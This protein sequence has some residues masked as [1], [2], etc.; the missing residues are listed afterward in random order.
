MSIAS[1]FYYIKFIVHRDKTMDDCTN[2]R[3]FANNTITI[4]LDTN[5]VYAY[6]FIHMDINSAFPDDHYHVVIENSMS[7]TRRVSAGLNSGIAGKLHGCSSNTSMWEAPYITKKI[8]LCTHW[9]YGSDYDSLGVCPVC[10]S[11][12]KLIGNST[13]LNTQ[14]VEM[15]QSN[16]YI[17]VYICIY[18]YIYIYIC[19][20]VC[21]CVC[22]V[23]ISRDTGF[24]FFDYI[25]AL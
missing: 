15:R 23:F 12:Q 10:H 16:I 19:V 9:Y 5:Y 20:C 6:F 22:V 4:L 21:V 3:T 2:S 1:H 8:F 14:S 11:K 18:I 17:Y 25:M 24:R 7:K 13:L